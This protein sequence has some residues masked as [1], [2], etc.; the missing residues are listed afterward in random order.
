M[1][2]RLDQSLTI[3]YALAEPQLCIKLWLNCK[4]AK[5]QNCKYEY[6]GIKPLDLSD[7]QACIF[8]W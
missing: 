3:S 8:N 5:L 7:L 6:N 2:E 4:T 1:I